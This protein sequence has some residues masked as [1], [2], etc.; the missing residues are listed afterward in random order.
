MKVVTVEE[1]RR[2]DAAC[3]REA[4]IST[5]VLMENAGLGVAQ[6]VRQL[7]GD[8]SRVPILVLV[9]PGN[10]GGDGLVVARHLQ[11]WG[12]R[13]T[14]YIVVPRPPDD[15]KLT[16]AEERGVM[17]LDASSDS[18]LESFRNALSSVRLVV[19]A[20]LGTGHLRPLRDTVRDVMTELGRQRSQRRELILLALDLPTGLDGDTG[21]VDPATPAFDVTV[22]LAF[23]K[24]GLFRFPGA[25]TVGRLE[26]VDIGIPAHLAEGISCELLTARWVAERLPS[27]PLDAHKGT[28]GHLLIVAGSRNYVG[29]AALAAEAAY[30][31]GAGLVTLATPA[32]IYPILAAS[33]IEAT[34]LPLPETEPGRLSLDAVPLVAEELARCDALLVGCGMGLYPDARLFLERLLFEKLPRELPTVVDADGLNN[35]ARVDNWWE[36][37]APPAILTP[38]PGEM[39]RLSGTSARELQEDRL[40]TART[41]AARWGKVVVLKGA[42]SV[43]ASPQGTTQISPFANPALASGG[44]G[45]V[46]AGAIAGLLTQG[47]AP[48]EAAACGVYLHGAAGEEARNALGDT[49]VIARDLL[50]ELPRVIKR[51]RA[52]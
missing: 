4:G 7:L 30:R 22:T 15:Q 11:D 25:A 19:D 24:A 35:L 44:T 5:D 36:R 34:H 51:L 41:W 8:V 12:A 50:G 27:R 18:G 42:F 3:I 52:G 37:I 16:Q 33:T 10:N 32:S 38:H 1:M 49:G 17:L 28:F 9:G 39:A 45:D 26:T 14:A 20:I 43:V 21:A 23:P 6:K 2:L 47:I 46:L 31:V 48:F 29:A 40:D 13:V